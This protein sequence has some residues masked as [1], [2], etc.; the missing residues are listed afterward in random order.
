MPVTLAEA[1][2]PEQLL[3]LARAGDRQAMGRLLE[4]YRQYLLLLARLQIGRRLQGKGDASDLV[5]ETFY[6]AHRDFAGFR[7]RSEAE[8]IAWLRQMLAT[9]LAGL[10]RRY[11]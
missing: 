3:T 7:G 9:S 1:S 8:L 11:L 6:K 10:V 5:Q 2:T 4:Q